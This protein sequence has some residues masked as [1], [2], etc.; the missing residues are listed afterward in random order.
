MKKLLALLLLAFL[1]APSVAQEPTVT[2]TRLFRKT[3]KGEH[4]VT[5]YDH[6]KYAA[7]MNKVDKVYL[8]AKALPPAPAT[9]DFGAK[10]EY[11]MLLNDQYGCCFYS[12]ICHHD[13]TMTGNLGTQSQFDLN[14]FR[15]RYLAL[16]GGDNGLSDEDVQGEWKGRYLADVKDA[17]IIDWLYLNTTDSLSITAGMYWFGGTQ[18]TFTVPQAWIN[19]SD[20]G[21]IWDA[22]TYRNNNNG[23]AVHWSGVDTNGNYKLVT[24]GTY[25]WITPAGVRVCNP[26]GFVVFSTRWFNIKGYAPN[27][28]HITQ[29]AAMWTAG[30]GKTIPASVIAQ[31]PPIGP[32]P[33]NPPDPPGPV[34]PGAT[35]ITLS[36]PLA[37]GTYQVVPAD[38]EVLPAGTKAKIKELLEIIGPLQKQKPEGKKTSMG[39]H[40]EYGPI[41]G[42]E[43]IPLD[44]SNFPP[45]MPIEQRVAWWK[46]THPEAK[47]QPLADKAKEEVVLQNVLAELRRVN[48]RLDEFERRVGNKEKHFA[49]KP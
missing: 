35:T 33:P 19:N 23:H 8:N 34:P 31:F 38:A 47:S 16:S 24:W 45:D 46:A 12:S 15:Q 7:R 9:F 48:L 17:K 36:K 42:R 6:A 4:L 28:K 10:V 20:T 22:P 18:F 41:V 26:S 11:P 27:G 3:T 5:F 43:S 32:T 44:P 29:L 30:G 37:A 14:V 2:T 40:D 49:S 1:A 25:V 13:Q 21:D 39:P